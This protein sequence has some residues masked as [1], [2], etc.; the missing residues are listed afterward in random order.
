MCECEESEEPPATSCQPV[1][2]FNILFYNFCQGRTEVVCARK[3]FWLKA[4]AERIAPNR[5]FSSLISHTSAISLL[6][7]LSLEKSLALVGVSRVSQVYTVVCCVF[8]SF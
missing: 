1:F 6:S 8:I 5:R 3:P 4:D 2:K 7:S